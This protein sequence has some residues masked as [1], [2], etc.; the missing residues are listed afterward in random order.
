[1][2]TDAAGGLVATALPWGLVAGLAL[3]ALLGLLALGLVLLAA[4]VWLVPGFG[5]PGVLGLGALGGGAVLLAAGAGVLEAAALSRAAGTAVAAHLAAGMGAA[6]FWRF[7]PDRRRRLARAVPGLVLTASV[8]GGT[9]AGLQ[10]AHRVALSDLRP[11]GGA[12]TGGARIGVARVYVVTH[13]E[14]EA[15]KKIAQAR[16]EERR[17]MAVAEERRCGP[18]WWRPKR[19]CNWPWRR[20]SAAGAWA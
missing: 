16:A 17:A 15:D 13:R 14:A 1:M 10:G 6:L 20:P 11:A 18:G 7:Q 3:L 4:E 9:R 2:G 8:G 5:V 12:R 19:P